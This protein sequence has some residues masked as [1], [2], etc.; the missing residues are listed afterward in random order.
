[1]AGLKLG[2]NVLQVGGSD[3]HLIAELA[4]V[5]GLSGRACAVAPTGGEATTLERAAAKAGVLVEVREAPVT[6][7]P[8]DDDFFDLIVLKNLLGRLYQN[9]RV[10][11]VQQVYRVLRVGGRCLVIDAAMRGG[12]AAIISRQTVD[13]RYLTAGGGKP[14]LE[15]EGFRGVRRLAERDGLVFVEGVKPTGPPD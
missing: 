1:M 10:A 8:Y 13:S 7:L 4:K 6:A 5:V 12:L 14:A 9:D 11:C 15:A 3:P 2:S